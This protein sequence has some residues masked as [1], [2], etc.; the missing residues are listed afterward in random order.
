MVHGA[1]DGYSRMIVYLKCADNN[2]SQTVLTNFTEAVQV[3]GVPS[4]V[5]SDRGGEN[6][7]VHEFMVVHRGANKASFI[8]GRSVHNQR[9]ERLWR[10]LYSACIVGFYCLFSHM[11]DIGILDVDNPAHLFCLHYIYLPR[12]NQSLQD[13]T[14]AW[15]EHPLSSVRNASPKQLWISGTH[16]QHLD[17]QV[18]HTVRCLSTCTNVPIHT[19]SLFVTTVCMELTGMALFL[20]HKRIWLPW[21]LP[22]SLFV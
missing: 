19:S 4:R 10:D 12:I 13:F 3:Y 2:T 6:V 20:F 1:I 21:N 11:E 17:E 8:A 22:S 5:R 18:S 7:L 15:N 16:P 9:I 14:S